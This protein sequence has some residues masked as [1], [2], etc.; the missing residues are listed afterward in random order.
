MT[1]NGFL[2]TCGFDLFWLI[3]HCYTFTY[4]D[5]KISNGF[6]GSGVTAAGNT[7]LAI[8]YTRTTQSRRN[9]R[10]RPTLLCL[11]SSTASQV[12]LLNYFS[13]YRDQASGQN[14]SEITPLKLW[15]SEQPKKRYRSH[16]S[17]V[18]NEPTR[19]SQLFFL[20]EGRIELRNYLVFFVSPWFAELKV[21]HIVFFH[22]SQIIIMAILKI[23][24]KSICNE[25]LKLCTA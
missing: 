16:N 11:T 3:T 21:I 12:I 10:V 4:H 25:I 2:G 24:S 5:F 15:P 7:L 19:R 6:I 13:T 23:D 14:N 20:E 22:H 9:F 1:T 8:I 18:L 17:S